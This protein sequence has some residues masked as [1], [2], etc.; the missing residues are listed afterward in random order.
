ML[1]N[2]VLQ[3]GPANS[4]EPTV[5]KTLLK[6][7]GLFTTETWYWIGVGALFAYS[8]LF[9]VLFV[10]ALTFLNRKYNLPTCHCDTLYD[11][12]VLVLICDINLT[13]SYWR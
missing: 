8:L 2:F 5:G 3:P 10:G 9:N 12:E 4:S 1:L 7:R 11:K 13:V 6:E